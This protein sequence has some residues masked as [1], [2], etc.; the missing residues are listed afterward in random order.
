[1]NFVYL[2]VCVLLNNIIR[3]YFPLKSYYCS[4]LAR[5]RTISR[6]KFI[7]CF[8]T[9]LQPDSVGLECDW[10]EC[11]VTLDWV[12]LKCPIGA[13]LV[14]IFCTQRKLRGLFLEYHLRMRGVRF[15]F[16][17][18][19]VWPSRWLHRVWSEFIKRI[20]QQK[21]KRFGKQKIS[22]KKNNMKSLKHGN[23]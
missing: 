10:S 23:N 2:K 14:F 13:R 7:Y 22:F 15:I 21:N 17:L 5:Y 1:M 19:C 6:H 12:S 20:S 8:K 16:F 3:K 4:S 9:R 11:W 18:L